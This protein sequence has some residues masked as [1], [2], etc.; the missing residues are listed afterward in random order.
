MFLQLAGT[1]LKVFYICHVTI[2]NIKLFEILRCIICFIYTTLFV[3]LTQ[4]SFNNKARAML[5]LLENLTNIFPQYG[6]AQQLYP[7]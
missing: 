6:Y 4:V 7:A 3:W 5:H 1:F 2:Q